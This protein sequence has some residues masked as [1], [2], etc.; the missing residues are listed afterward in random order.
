MN[1]C[2]SHSHCEERI[3]R[4]LESGVDRNLDEFSN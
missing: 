3:S 4:T 2:Y 1:G